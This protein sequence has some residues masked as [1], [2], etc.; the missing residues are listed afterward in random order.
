MGGNDHTTDMCKRLASTFGY[1][2][3]VANAAAAGGASTPAAIVSSL[4]DSIV[5]DGGRRF[6][7]QGF[8]T[9]LDAAFHFEK[10]IAQ[11]LFVLLA[12]GVVE[13]PVAD[14]YAKV[15]P[16]GAGVCM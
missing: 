15:R 11:P 14:L 16:R 13:G 10:T 5:R 6:I 2:H 1:A 3:L 12:N 8:P 9:T 7:I 4:N